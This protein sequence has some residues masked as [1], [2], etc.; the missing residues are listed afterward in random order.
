MTN[1]C[2][3]T[4]TPLYRKISKIKFE[5]WKL[6]QYTDAS[7][8]MTWIHDNYNPTEYNVDQD[9]KNG[10]TFKGSITYLVSE[11]VAMGFKLRWL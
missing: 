7:V 1:K 5:W 3:V 4:L 2:T 6:S 11:T 9:S 10:S 8:M